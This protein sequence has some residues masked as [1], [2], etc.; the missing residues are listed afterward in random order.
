MREETG[1]QETTIHLL[2]GQRPDGQLVFEQVKAKNMGDSCYELLVPPLFARGA[3][4]GDVIR[5][6][7]AGRFAVEQHNGNLSV[8]VLAKEGLD[9]IKRR[10]ES[11][12]SALEAELDFENDRTLV[13]SIHIA[14]GF[15]RIEAA[16]NQALQGRD[17]AM[18]LY[19]N[20]YDADGETPLNWWHDYLAK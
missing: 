10:L 2:A 1:T 4:K 5:L 15:D 16:F 18:W 7:A 8:R 20:V 3:A 13:Y 12:L 14:A 9:E 17:D 19:A 11:P 6:F